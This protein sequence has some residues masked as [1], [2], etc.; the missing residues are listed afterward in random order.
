[1]WWRKLRNLVAIAAGRN[2]ARDKCTAI[3]LSQ[4]VLCASGIH[5]QRPHV[6]PRFADAAR[7]WPRNS[8]AA[9]GPHARGE[10]HSADRLREFIRAHARTHCAKDARNFSAFVFGC[11]A[12]GDPAAT[13]D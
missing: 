13:L 8:R 6:V 2:L 12:L 10:L 3:T 5:V 9:A 7:S 4:S 11:H 1:M